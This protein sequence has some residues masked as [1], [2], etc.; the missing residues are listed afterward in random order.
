MKALIISTTFLGVLLLSWW[1]FSDYADRSLE[2]LMDMAENQ[3]LQSARKEHW[4]I[5]KHQMEEF[6][7]KWHKDKKIYS[8]FFQ[9][10]VINEIDFS[11]ARLGEY[12]RSEDLTSTSG[13]LAYIKEQLKYLHANEKFTIENIF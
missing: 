5:A 6:T 13:E 7:E 1:A 8:Y 11:I 12:V 10:R 9:T 2:P 4:D 3:L